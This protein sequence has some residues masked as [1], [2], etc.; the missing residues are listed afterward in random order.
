METPAGAIAPSAPFLGASSGAFYPTPTERAPALAARLGLSDLEIMLQTAGEYAP[1]F[2]RRLATACDGEGRRVHAVHLWQQLHPLLSPYARRAREGRVAFERAIE[3]ARTL[4]AAVL[5]WHGPTPAELAVPD[6]RSRFADA[7]GTL[8]ARCGEAGIRLA[9]ENVSWCALAQARE[10]A[11]FATRTSG[12]DSAARPG[13]VFDPFQAAEAGANPFLILASMGDRL[14]DVHLSDRSADDPTARHLPPGDGDL[15]W[16]ALLRAIVG[17]GYRGPLM[18][19]APL[20]P[21]GITL[22]RVRARLDP[23]LAALVAGGDGRDGAPPPGVVEGIALF[24][25]R[26]F[27]DAHEAIELEWHAERGDRRR[28]YQGILQI[29]VGFHHVLGGNHR[30]AVLLLTDGIAKVSRFVPRCLG[31]DTGRLVTESAACL[32]VIEDLGP[33]GLGRFDPET[34][35]MVHAAA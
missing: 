12:L 28:L 20:D 29:G 14:V 24:N 32:A 13:F 26:R 34:I 23:L 2:A 4:S 5:V 19:E 18:I 35:P 30:G 27:Y 33:D 9:I 6:G 25:A 7:A 10:V 16:A 21:D 31:L 15:P 22:A 1:R 17:T 11:A 3:V 8:G